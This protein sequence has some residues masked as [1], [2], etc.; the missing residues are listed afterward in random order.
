MIGNGKKST[1]FDGYFKLMREYELNRPFVSKKVLVICFIL[2]LL[3]V[4]IDA[5][6]GR[7][8]TETEKSN[9][10][11]LTA[12]MKQKAHKIKHALHKNVNFSF[13]DDDFYSLPE[14]VLFMND[15][16]QVSLTD[17]Y[18]IRHSF[19]GHLKKYEK[20]QD[21]FTQINLQ[22]AIAGDADFL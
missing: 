4:F 7:K 12:C 22:P 8:M 9:L 20:Q 10:N 21:V 3:P 15:D 16:I 13:M 11:K 19:K 6:S 5:Y 1:F 17:L 2:M 18:A 14:V